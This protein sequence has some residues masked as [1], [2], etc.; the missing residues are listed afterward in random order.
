MR[1]LRTVWTV[2]LS[3]GFALVGPASAEDISGTITTT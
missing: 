3:L 2:A 1:Q